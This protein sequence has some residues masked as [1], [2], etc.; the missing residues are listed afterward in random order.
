MKLNELN[1]SKEIY[2]NRTEHLL[3]ICAEECAEVAQRCS[4]ALRFGAGEIQ[5][6]QHQ[7]NAERITEEVNDLMAVLSMMITE[8]IIPP[9]NYNRINDKEKKIEKYLRYS[10]SIGTLNE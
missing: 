4:K 6:E 7:T 9:V 5:N 8:K 2:M 3:T 10:K 1:K